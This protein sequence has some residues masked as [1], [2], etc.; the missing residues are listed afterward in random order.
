MCECVHFPSHMC[1]QH[2]GEINKCTSIV[3]KSGN[4]S[5][6]P[7]VMYERIESEHI[8][9]KIITSSG[10]ENSVQIWTDFNKRNFV[11]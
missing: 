5:E 7:K 9:F 6:S 8:C 2:M 4:E 3:I 10:Y 1:K 11:F